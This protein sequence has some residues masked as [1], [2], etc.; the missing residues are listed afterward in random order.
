MALLVFGLA[1]AELAVRLEPVTAAPEAPAEAV[2]IS[3]DERLFTLMAAL[4]AAGYDDENNQAGMHPVRQAARAELA[5]R[6]LPSLARLRPRL[7]LCRLIHESQCIHWLLQRGGPPDFSRQAGGW[8]VNAPAFPFLGL[9][10]ALSD[11]YRE[12][13]IAE[14][15]QRYRPAYEAEAA[16]YQALLAPSLQNT[17]DYLRMSPPATGRVIML[18]NLLD[19]YWRG[20]GPAVGETSYIV[21][22]PAE[23]PNI[24]LLQ[25][26]FMHPLLNPLVDANLQAIDPDQA[27]RLYDHLKGQVS[28]G[29][30]N[31]DG[32]LRESVIRAVEVRL[33]DP[34]ERARFLANEEEQGFWL[35]RPLAHQLEAY[36]DTS[37]SLPEFMPTWLASLN[38]LDAARL[39]PESPASRP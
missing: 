5:A 26:E 20:Y 11:F 31:W 27:R 12:A 9:S 23:Q 30:Q 25:H 24:G 7:Q 18:P 10:G 33:A 2:S 17:L 1:A 6:N 28:R 22:G 35:V 14:L 32:I 19:A 16:R 8:W 15:W 34:D 37:Q 4:N 36:E 39:G 3:A 13:G 21:S 29:Y 38:N